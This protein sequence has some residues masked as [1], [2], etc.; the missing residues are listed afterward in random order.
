M[1]FVTKLFVASIV[2]LPAAAFA[3]PQGH[4]AG[5]TAHTAH[6]PTH[7]STHLTTTSH[8]SRHAALTQSGHGNPHGTAARTAH[9]S[10]HGP[11]STTSHGSVT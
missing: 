5:I 3:G 6:P 1:R 7:A 11:V 2:A 10:T 8:E 4:G 9:M